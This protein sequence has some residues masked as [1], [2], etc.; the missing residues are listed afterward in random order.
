MIRS[1]CDYFPG[2]AGHGVYCEPPQPGPSDGSLPGPRAVCRGQQGRQSMY[3][4]HQQVGI[5]LC[6]KPGWISWGSVG[7]FQPNLAQSI[8][9]YRGLK[10][11]KKEDFSIL[12]KE[13][14]IFS[15]NQHYGIII[16]LCTNFYWLELFLG[17]ALWPT[18]LLLVYIL[19]SP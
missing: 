16:A 18:G 12:K 6:L 1:F 17:W 7:Q 2:P 10:F 3:Q 11:K 5:Y 15:L 9:M 8:L 13:I 14:L 19:S 4:L